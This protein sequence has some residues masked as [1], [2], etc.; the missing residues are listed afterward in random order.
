MA[1][2]RRAGGVWRKDFFSHSVLPKRV[3]LPSFQF[4]PLCQPVAASDLQ[5]PPNLHH[6]ET[7]NRDV[8]ERRCEGDGRPRPHRGFLLG[9]HRQELGPDLFLF[10]DCIRVLAA[11]HDGRHADVLQALEGDAGNKNNT[12]Q[13]EKN[14]RS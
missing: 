10:N 11:L 4:R 14:P 7:N 8:F 5:S 13:D 6:L 9:L 12:A 1:S 2:E 3:T